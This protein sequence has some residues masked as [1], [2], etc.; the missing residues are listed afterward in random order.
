VSPEAAKIDTKVGLDNAVRI[1]AES[2][3]ELLMTSATQDRT[4]RQAE[5]DSDSTETAVALESE[6]ET[7]QFDDK[8]NLESALNTEKVPCDEG[9]QDVITDTNSESDA[10]LDSDR[11]VD[12][13]R[14]RTL[15]STLTG[16][17]ARGRTNSTSLTRLDRWAPASDR[18]SGRERSLIAVP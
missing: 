5:I 4:Q 2:E 18:L 6:G 10:G 14:R 8:L 11:D 15:S 16:I 17:A 12:R 1:D 3:G 9:P 7:N 13:D